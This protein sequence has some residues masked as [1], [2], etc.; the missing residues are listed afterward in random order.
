MSRHGISKKYDILWTQQRVDSLDQ[1]FQTRA[2]IGHG[3]HVGTN[4]EDC[5]C[6]AWELGMV[7]QKVET[8]FVLCRVS[9]KGLEICI[10][11]LDATINVNHGPILPIL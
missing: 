10:V 2:E 5:D 1:M 7:H 9:K 6:A 4:V 3:M 8:R 11:R